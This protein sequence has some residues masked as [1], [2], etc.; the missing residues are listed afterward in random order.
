MTG[1][2]KEMFKLL[3]SYAIMVSIPII[4]INIIITIS[5]GWEESWILYTFPLGLIIISLIIKLYLRRE[6]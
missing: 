2:N 4:L 6:K 5:K 3:S 1:D